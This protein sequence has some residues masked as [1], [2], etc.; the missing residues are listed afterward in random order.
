MTTDDIDIDRERIA[1]VFGLGGG[2]LHEP[3]PEFPDPAGWE[4]RDVW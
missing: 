2:E 3:H 4:G 1:C